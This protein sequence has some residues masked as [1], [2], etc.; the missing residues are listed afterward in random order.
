MRTNLRLSNL[1]EGTLQEVSKFRLCS[2]L[3][4]QYRHA[5]HR[6]KEFAKERN[7]DSYSADLLGCFLADIEQKYE[8][9]AIGHSRRNHLRRASFLLRDYVADGKVEWRPYGGISQPMPSSQEF[10]SFYSQYL[11]SLKSYGKSENTIQSSRNLVRQFLLFLDDNSYTALSQTP[12]DMVPSFFQHLLATYK[13]TSIRTVA[14]HI[15]SFLEFTE[16]GERFLPLVPSGCVRNR[17]IIPILSDK[18]DAALKRVLKSPEVPLRDKAIIQLAL[19]TGLRS[20]DIVGMKLSDIDWVN[21]TILIPQ[22]KTGRPFRIPLSADVGNSLSSYILTERPTTDTPYVF[23]R[24]LAPFK[25]LCGHSACY[26][27]VRKSFARAGIRLG[28]ERKGIHVIRHSAASRMLSRGVPVTTISSVLGHANKSS[29]DVYLA[30]DE[31]RMRECGL[32]LA[33]IPMNCGGLR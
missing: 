23:L 6:L 29:T 20:I 24:S 25:P 19:R 10:L 26:A 27:V 8:T 28:R 14:S 13:P 15:R 5:F 21:D 11:D 17:P 31:P 16:G 30:T 12:L 7:M 1:I 2:E 4:C 33:G 9:G 3:I 32:P 22:S 18:E